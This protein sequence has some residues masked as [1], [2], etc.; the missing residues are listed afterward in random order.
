MWDYARL[1][2]IAKKCGGLRDW[3]RPSRSAEPQSGV[4]ELYWCKS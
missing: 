4:R 1:A 2:Q 3:L